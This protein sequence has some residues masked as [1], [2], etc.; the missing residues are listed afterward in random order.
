MTDERIRKQFLPY[1]Q[2][3]AEA[4]EGVKNYVMNA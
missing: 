2:K 3:E 1:E 4:E